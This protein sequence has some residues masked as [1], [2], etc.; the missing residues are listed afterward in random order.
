MRR[1]SLVAANPRITYYAVGFGNGPTDE[2]ESV[3]TFNV[4]HPSVDNGMFIPVG[5][6]TTV[7]AGFRPFRV[8]VEKETTE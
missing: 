5:L 2:P 6:N 4:F 3:G 7:R 8:V 1:T